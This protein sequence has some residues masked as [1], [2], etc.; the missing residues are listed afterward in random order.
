MIKR[1][2]IV[3]LPCYAGHFIAQLLTLD[4]KTIPNSTNEISLNARLNH[5]N[6]SNSKKFAHYS[7]FH[8]KHNQ[9]WKTEEEFKNF[10]KVGCNIHIFNTHPQY[11]TNVPESN[12]NMLCCLSYDDFSNFWLQYSKKSFGANWPPL[13]TTFDIECLKKLIKNNN[14]VKI[15]IDK[16]LNTDT[17]FSEYERISNFLS[18]KV[19][20]DEAQ[21]LYKSWYDV[22]V[23]KAH[24]IFEKLSNTEK[25]K[26]YN[27]RLVDEHFY[28]F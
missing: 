18:L 9:P 27:Q 1:I 12:T 14:V 24:Q 13:P 23:K 22:R 20:K 26:F 25:K 8:Q 5:Y 7:L 6:F 10:E 11:Y 28:K 2:A 15:A 17:W 21:V 4:E 19:F 16:F 3:Y